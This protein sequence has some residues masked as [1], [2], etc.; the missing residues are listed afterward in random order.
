MAKSRTP[1]RPNEYALP[2]FSFTRRLKEID[3]FFN[4]RDKVHQTMRR[5]AKRLE[6]AKIPYAIMGAMAVNAHGARRTTDD[7]DVLLTVEG[8]QRFRE[9]FVDSVYEQVRGRQRR[10]KEKQS[11]VG[12][13]VLLTGA[14]PGS[15]EP[16]PVQF[17]DPTMAG[18]EIEKAQFVALAELIQL[19]LAARRHYDF[20]DVV[21]LIRTHNLDESFA[22]QLHPVVRQDYIECFEEKRRDDEYDAR[23]DPR[24]PE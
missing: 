9:T 5:L 12:V 3:M 15:G 22:E 21:L 6:K 23:P 14:Y 20:G 1:S 16:G 10:F 11:G 13:D 17:P 19:K 24:I 8:F 4:K 7:V 18:I 2:G